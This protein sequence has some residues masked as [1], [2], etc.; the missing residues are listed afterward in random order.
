MPTL[1]GIDC[2][3]STSGHAATLVS[4]GKH[5]VCRYVAP[6][7]DV[8][9]W[10]RLTKSEANELKAHHLG[11]VIVFESYASRA[12]EGH[13]SGV[14][15]AHAA[16]ANA[17]AA[18]VGR[19]PI[20]FA[21]DFSPS[22]SQLPAILAYL[23]GAQSVLG[24]KRVGVY[25]SA[26]VVSFCL[27]HGVRFAWQTYAWSGGVLA[28]D[29]HL[30]Q[31]HNGV[32]VAGISADLTRALRSNYGQW[33]R[34]I[35]GEI[36]AGGKRRARVLYGQGRVAKLLGRRKWLAGLAKQYGRFGFRRVGGK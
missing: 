31:Y 13:A 15:D 22:S 6:S 11:I 30:Y 10:K 20:Y 24:K 36:W 3:Q 17:K 12:G 21:V 8:Y 34:P 5:F 29:V 2:A 4:A 9:D 35:Y 27:S 28:R 7:N 32:T 25:G 16:L 18:G 23:Q 19:A 1:E 14:A 33:K 26:A